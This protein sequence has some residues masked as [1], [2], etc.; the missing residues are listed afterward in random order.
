MTARQQ[1]PGKPQ[2]LSDRQ[3]RNRA[4]M[5]RQQQVADAAR[6][7][8]KVVEVAPVARK[9]RMHLRHWL[10]IAS[11]LAFVAAPAA[12]VG[13][14][15]YT[16][17]ADQYASVLGFTV[18]KEE[19]SSPI[20]L[21]GG[22]S[23]FSGNSS[24][25]TDILYEFIQSVPLVRAVD[26]AL[27]LQALYSAPGF[28]PVF[29]LREN[30]S[31]EHLAA[32][33]P[34]MV[35]ISYDSSSRLIEVEARAFRPE[36]AQAIAHEILDRSSVMINQLSAVAREDTTR[37]AREE[38]DQGVARLKTARQAMQRFRNAN[39]IV[40]PTADISSQMGLLNSL[41]TQLAE[42]LISLDLLTG[43]TTANDPRIEQ[44]NRKIEAIERRIA[45]ERLKLG[46]GGGAQSSGGAYADLVGEYESLQVDLE[47]AQTSYLA[48]LASHESAIAEARR[49]SRYLAAYVLP[50]LAE[51]PLYPQ[52]LIS[53]VVITLILSGFWL[54]A[55]LVFYSLRDRR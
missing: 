36:D 8:V 17:A 55:V 15:L 46:V 52:R 24:S 11:F 6:D 45:D 44:T 35:R 13:F 49:Q 7:S 53:L 54:I 27:D 23:D 33:W 31:I 19:S 10:L 50:T 3:K 30:A 47:F 18:R 20:D 25:D 39:Q 22:L 5:H 38:L 12:G 40:D 51:T 26:G 14:Y 43:A 28:D 29:S 41:Q 42:A 37:V 4:V 48:A 34:R 32:Y 1:Q 2:N 16:Y 21:L 9:A